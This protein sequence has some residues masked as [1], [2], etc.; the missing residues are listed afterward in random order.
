MAVRDTD[1]CR[2]NFEMSAGFILAEPM[3]IALQMAG[4]QGDAHDVV[5]KILV[6][7]AKREGIS[8]A[9]A[10]EK[11]M[12]KNTDLKE[13]VDNIPK[14]VFD[15]F[16]RPENYIGNSEKKAMEVVDLAKTLV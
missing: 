6:P 8:L 16:S 7:M 15:L 5:N 10:L 11:E 12:G 1:K 14:E 4:F 3:Y 13:A 9:Q 2:E